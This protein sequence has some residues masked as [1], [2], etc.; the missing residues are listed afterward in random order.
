MIDPT[1]FEN[2]VLRGGFTIVRIELSTEPLVDAFE[3]EVIARTRIIGRKF[4]IAIRSGLRDDEFSVTLYHEVLE[5]ATVA[6]A[7][8]PLTMRDFNDEN[9][10]RAA[11][12]P[13]TQFGAAS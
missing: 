7:S 11:Y 8:P 2:V 1:L 9:S 10:E 13:R 4:E 6:A 12:S 5:A 3:R